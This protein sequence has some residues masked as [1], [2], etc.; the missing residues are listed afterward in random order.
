M[1]LQALQIMCFILF[2][3]VPFLPNDEETR[4]KKT[5]DFLRRYGKGFTYTMILI[6]NYVIPIASILL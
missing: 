1:I 6:Y 2:F 3:F 5:Q 4:W